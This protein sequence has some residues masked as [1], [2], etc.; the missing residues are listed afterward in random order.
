[1]EFPVVAIIGLEE[2]V[3]PHS[4][5]RGNINELEE[6]RRLF[7]V[8]I[9]RAQRQ[10]LLT[11]AAYRT[12]RGL[13]ERTVTSPFFNEL[14]PGDLEV[15]DRTGIPSRDEYYGDTRTSR[16]GLGDDLASQFRR[17]QMVRHPQFG[18][19]RIAD[20]SDMGQHTRAVVEFNTAGRKTLILQYARLEPV[21]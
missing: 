14:P 12:I 1:L 16:S 9:T 5:A 19:G 15:T 13:R 17:G 7:F 6:E 11:K 2:G 18:L 21:G 10:L 20:V 8:G 4:R 3:L